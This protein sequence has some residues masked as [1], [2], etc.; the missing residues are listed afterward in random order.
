MIIS[1]YLVTY[2]SI[3][4]MTSLAPIFCCMIL[5]ER[6]KP[7]FEKYIGILF[8]Y[9]IQPTILVIF[10]LLVD[11]I[12]SDQ[13]LNCLMD[14]N[15]GVYKEIS[16]SLDLRS[17][18]IGTNF[19][20]IKLTDILGYIPYISYIPFFIPEYNDGINGIFANALLF[21]SLSLVIYQAIP[22]V[23][24]IV[25]MLTSTQLPSMRGNES[26]GDGAMSIDQ[27][28]ISM[29]EN[30]KDTLKQIASPFINMGSYAYNNLKSL[31]QS[32]SNNNTQSF[33]QPASNN[34]NLSEGLS[35]TRRNSDKLEDNNNTK[36]TPLK[37]NKFDIDKQQ[38]SNQSG[39]EKESI[40]RKSIE[41]IIKDK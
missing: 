34:S 28:I 24:Q 36:K 41:H 18:G 26:R 32:T 15:W 38:S 31:R 40:R 9:A 25:Q 35:D 3:C 16:L 10:I 6:T 14:C 27:N 8:N 22:Y 21:S 13:L 39:K 33:N 1:Y 37:S 5:F 2:V 30:P 12:L 7:M 19:G 29:I 4:V 17:L 20:T 23:D 11:Q